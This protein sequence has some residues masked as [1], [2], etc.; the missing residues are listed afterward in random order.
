MMKDIFKT[1][2]VEEPKIQGGRT[3]PAPTTFH[4]KPVILTPVPPKE[5][6]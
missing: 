5:K 6:K 2:R 1:T 4:L 3:N